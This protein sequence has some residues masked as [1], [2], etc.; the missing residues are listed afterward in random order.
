MFRRVASRFKA[1]ASGT[2]A[3]AASASLPDN[4]AFLSQEEIDSLS[5]RGMVEILDR[6]IIGQ[7]DAKKAVAIS[8]RNRWRRRQIKD[9]GLRG[10]IM[11][12]NILMIGPTGV[13][14]TEISRR[15]ARIT[16]A[17]FIKV[18]ATKYTEVGFKGKDVESIIEDLFA[19]AKNKTRRRLERDREDEAMQATYDILYT[20]YMRAMHVGGAWAADSAAS[21]GNATAAARKVEDEEE[22]EDDDVVVTPAAATPVA[23]AAGA[24][25]APKMTFDQFVEKL[26]AGELDKE[27]VT[28]DVTVTPPERK[29]AGGAADLGMLLFGGAQQKIVQQMRHPIVEAL[30]L[31]KREVLGKL[32]DDSAVQV[33][34][35]TL[36]EQEGIVFLDEI[37]K[38]VS[39]SNS[40][41]SDVSSMGVQQDLLPL[42][43][44]S[45]VTLKDGTTIET[46]CILFICSGAFHLAKPSDMIA[47]LQ[48]RLPV[49]VELQPLTEKEFRRILIEP[50]FNLLAQQRA[51]MKTEDVTLEFSDGGIDAIAKV[52]QKVNSGAQNI[53]ARRLHTI[54]EMV[55]DEYSFDFEPHIGKKI[56]I[57]EA[58]V[59]EKTKSLTVNVDLS[60]YIL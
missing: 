26:K 52:S 40:S 43:E 42:I 20:A 35:K 51:M 18:E 27:I 8:L 4:S 1:S 10:D 7:T 30:P 19:N 55:M 44:G 47:E 50:K 53:G 17:P 57:D 59:T 24:A 11:P 6:F 39:D 21:A 22:D 60:K 49:R 3:A 56:V 58:Y 45:T 37:D 34:A 33:A 13:G 31:A 12:K 25:T 36:C 29:G 16:D 23:G 48:G 15:M 46:D 32:I 5:P 38:V 54:I 14:K 28:I 2:A 41:A 9:D